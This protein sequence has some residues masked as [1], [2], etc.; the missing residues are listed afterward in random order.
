MMDIIMTTTARTSAFIA[1]RER[2][3]DR[4]TTNGKY[5]HC[6]L[7]LFGLYIGYSGDTW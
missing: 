7:T 6:I 3:A 2:D 5:G 4:T 1:P